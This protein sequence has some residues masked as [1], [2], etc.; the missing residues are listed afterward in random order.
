VDKVRAR[1]KMLRG[2]MG[3]LFPVGALARMDV[4]VAKH[5]RWLV[6]GYSLLS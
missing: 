1:G 6:L 4:A 3:C 2:V 5:G